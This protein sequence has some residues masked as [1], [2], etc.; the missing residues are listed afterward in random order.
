VW[1]NQ[2]NGKT[3][4]ADKFVNIGKNVLIVSQELDC[5]GDF[6]EEEEE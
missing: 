6:S 3:I 1:K 4:I 5:V 2:G